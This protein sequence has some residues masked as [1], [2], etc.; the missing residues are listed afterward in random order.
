MFRFHRNHYNSRIGTSYS[1][2]YDALSMGLSRHGDTGC[3]LIAVGTWSGSKESVR[4][5]ALT[6]CVKE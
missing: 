3:K 5:D 4:P 1:P 6:S 2:K